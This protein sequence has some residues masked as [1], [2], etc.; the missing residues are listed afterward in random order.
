[1]ISV[2]IPLYNKANMISRTLDSVLSQENA[3]FE[4]IVV[5][6]GSIDDSCEIVKA[7]R[8][9][10]LLY[11]RKEN[12][13]VSSARN[14][15]MERSHGEWIF[16]LD[17]DD[18]MYPDTL[19]FFSKMYKKYPNAKLLSGGTKW[20]NGDKIIRSENQD[21]NIYISNN[22]YFDIWRNKI[23]PHPGAMMVHSS[24]I[25]RY[26]GF[27]ARLKFFEDYEFTLRILQNGCLVAYSKKTVMCYNQYES[28]A[29]LKLH[30]YKNEMAYLVPEFVSNC[31][32]WHK[33]LLFENIEFT[34]Y[35][36]VNENEAWDYY[37]GVQK[38]Y[39]G[40]IHFALHSIRQRLGRYKFL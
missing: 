30:N 10:R 23:Y 22:P 35:F 32:F 17:A 19:S 11:F 18:E 27:N 5:D 24:L 1:M 12:G 2:I 4:V 33:A 20:V 6:D 36:H 8:D 28:G 3:E 34:K 37:C 15:G 26:G 29:S 9:N 40:K 7:K 38:K 21:D 13:G 14:Y 31:S 39:F 16:F 25:E